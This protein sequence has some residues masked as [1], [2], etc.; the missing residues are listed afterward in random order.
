MAPIQTFDRSHARSFASIMAAPAPIPPPPDMPD[1]AVDKKSGVYQLG[2]LKVTYV[3]D[4]VTV[5]KTE[6]CLAGK[7]P[8][9]NN[10]KNNSVNFAAFCFIAPCM[11]CLCEEATINKQCNQ[12]I[13]EDYILRA[14][15][16]S[17][18]LNTFVQQLVTDTHLIY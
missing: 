7:C 15:N 3:L 10:A 11:H 2:L 8:K 12:R 1:A 9:L 13:P 18:A 14:V 5:G 17:I 16:S 6:Y 4:T